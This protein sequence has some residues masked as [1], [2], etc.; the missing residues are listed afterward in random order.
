MR[1]EKSRGRTAPLKSFLKTSLPAAVD[2]AS[3]TIMWTIEAIFIGKLGGAALAGHSMAIQIVLVF[4]AV[5]ITFVVGAGLIINRHLGAGEKEKADHM[6][7]QALFMAVAMALLFSLIWHFG[8]VQLFRLIREGGA[9]DARSA[10][11]SYL[12]T[13]SYFGPLIMTNFVATGIIR[14]VGDTRLSMRINLVINL[15]DLMLAPI[16]IF[17]L[18]GVQNLGVRG[19]A[20]AVGVAHSIG[21]FLTLR[22]LRSG[23]ARLYLSYREMSSPDWESF[24]Q[25]FKNGLPT[26]IEQL[27]WALGQLVVISYAG[28]FSVTVLGTHAIFMRLQNVLSMIYMGFSLAAMSA[29]GQQLGAARHDEALKAAKTSH[30][31]MMGF[32]GLMVILLIVFSEKFIRIFTV[33]LQIESL[34]RRAIFIFALAQIPKAL[35]NVLSGNLRGAGELKWLMMNTIAFVLLFEIGLNYV[36]VFFLAGGIYGIWC[37]Q[38]LDELI[39]LGLNFYRFDNGNWRRLVC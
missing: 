38:A 26:T 11:M 9:D 24:K 18:F 5:L 33:D 29:M 14:A 27:A 16:F 15:I 10:G 34:G 1:P 32:V 22:L 17:G 8:A 28:M 39:R 35:N 3:Q 20:L 21:F 30:R 13:V 37:I 23:R 4:F 31:A 36:A 7:G 19:A 25:L 6:L 2:L 12:R